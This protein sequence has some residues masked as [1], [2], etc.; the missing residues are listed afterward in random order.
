MLNC[1]D[2]FWSGRAFVHQK[3]RI[4][5]GNCRLA[6]EMRGEAEGWRKGCMIVFKDDLSKSPFSSFVCTQHTSVSESLSAFL[7]A[8]DVRT[9][10]VRIISY[11]SSFFHISFF[12]FQ[13]SVVF[14]PFWVK[15]F[16]EQ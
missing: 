15:D 6:L 16:D 12:L 7:T 11:Q 13:V 1:S 9:M 8:L 4:Q 14:F 10:S 3:K 2:S 5:L